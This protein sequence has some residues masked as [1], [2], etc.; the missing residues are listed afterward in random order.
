MPQT[1]FKMGAAERL[2]SLALVGGAWSASSGCGTDRFV[3]IQS[4]PSGALVH[5]NDQ[6]VGRTPVTV[7]F[8]YYGVYDVRLRADGFEP[9]WTEHR[10]VAPFWEFPPLDLIG[11]AVGADVDLHW[12]FA[13]EPSPDAGDASTDALLGRAR[14]LRQRAMHDR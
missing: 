2:L 7:P 4:E 9:L 14:A 10:A 12:S 3:T 13:L 8:T 5:L 6:E 1:R 11:E